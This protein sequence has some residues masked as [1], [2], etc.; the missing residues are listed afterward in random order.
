VQAEVLPEGVELEV[1]PR[2]QDRFEILRFEEGA[3]QVADRNLARVCP[4]ALEYGEGSRRQA[5]FSINARLKKLPT[6][7]RDESL[8][9]II[10]MAGVDIPPDLGRDLVLSWDEVREMSRRGISFGAHSVNH[11]I[12]SQLPLDEAEKEILDSRRHI[13][14]ELEREVTTFCYPN[15]EPDDFNAGI[16]EILRRNG[17]KG[18]V[19]LAPA[20][21]VSPGAP[22][23]DCRGFRARQAPPFSSCSCPGCIWT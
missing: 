18:A 22:P 10:E 4:S 5:A 20:A 7:K 1:R 3:V 2:G 14:K 12:L 8:R 17:F 23:I 19:T 16:E 11:P 9:R 15:G 21:F 13:E 6:D